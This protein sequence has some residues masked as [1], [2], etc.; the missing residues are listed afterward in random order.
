MSKF[1]LFYTLIVIHTLTIHAQQKQMEKAE[2][3]AKF[4]TF[5]SFPTNHNKSITIAVYNN[6][7]QYKEFDNYFVN[8]NINNQPINI[9][10]VKN[11][12]E[13]KN[14]QV[15]FI[16]ENIENEIDKVLKMTENKPILTITTEEKFVYKGIILYFYQDKNGVSHKINRNSLNK[17]GLKM[18]SEL[19][20]EKYLI[21]E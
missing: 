4:L 13:I 1:L 15:L 21:N 7:E 9:V 20:N 19:L 14:Q 10:H 8:K 18:K 6:E 17:S 16:G 11:I 3:I 2:I 12:L 5:T